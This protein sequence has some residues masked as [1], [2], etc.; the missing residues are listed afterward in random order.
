L[1]KAFNFIKQEGGVDTEASYPY[2]AQVSKKG[3][4]QRG[5]EESSNLFTDRMGLVDS[6][7]VILEPKSVIM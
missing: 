7:V 4:G 1:I 6:V 3:G 5:M 2:E